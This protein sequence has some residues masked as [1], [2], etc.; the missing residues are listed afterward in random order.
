MAGKVNTPRIEPA[1]GD[2]GKKMTKKQ[3]VAQL[4]EQAASMQGIASIKL[5]IDAILQSNDPE[6]VLSNLV[7]EILDNEQRALTDES[8]E[9]YRLYKKML[10]KVLNEAIAYGDQQ[11]MLYMLAD[12]LGYKRNY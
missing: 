2:N 4:K 9:Q 3:T 1:E 12:K 6:P 8:K 5:R 11:N 7:D 10:G